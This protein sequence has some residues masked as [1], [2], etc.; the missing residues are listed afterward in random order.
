MKSTL[1]SKL[2][3]V[4]TKKF[5]LTFEIKK[6]QIKGISYSLSQTYIL[7]NIEAKNN[8]LKK[9]FSTIYLLSSSCSTYLL[10]TI[11]TIE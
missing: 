8:N 1:L 3:W 4:W 11:K 10:L 9:N 2:S 7:I 6:K 5:Y